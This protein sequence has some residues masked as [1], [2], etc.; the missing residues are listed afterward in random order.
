MLQKSIRS[1]NNEVVGLKS[2]IEKM[3]L[4]IKNVQDKLDATLKE[5]ATMTSDIIGLNEWKSK[6]EAAHKKERDA[7]ESTIARLQQDLDNAKRGGKSSD[8]TT[9]KMKQ[10]QDSIATKESDIKQLKRDL[11]LSLIHI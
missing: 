9:E 3:T 4:E 5:K 11:L 8:D 1:K 2:T 7:L 10:L 6:A